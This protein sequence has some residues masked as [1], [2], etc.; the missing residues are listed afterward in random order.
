LEVAKNFVKINSKSPWKKLKNG[1]GRVEYPPVPADDF[2]HI[3]VAPQQ[4]ICR[5]A[6][7]PGE[8]GLRQEEFQVVGH[9]GGM[10]NIAYGREAH[11]QD[12]GAG[13]QPYCFIHKV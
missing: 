11:Q 10:E 5:R 9:G 13:R 6:A 2:I 7:E 4:V 1:D 3:R 12:A 8:A